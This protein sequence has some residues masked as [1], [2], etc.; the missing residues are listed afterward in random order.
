M[1][2]IACDHGGLELKAAVIKMLKARGEAVTDLGT[3][4][5]KSV[6]YPDYGF[7][8]AEK[9]AAESGSAG[10]VICKTGVGMS[11][12][13][14]KVKGVRCALCFTPEMGRLCREHNNANVLALGA[15]NTDIPA[16]LDIVE[17]FLTTEFAGGRHANRVGKIVNYEEQH[18]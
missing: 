2:Y 16:A 9:V 10:I 17:A 4:S 13:A 14:N 18:G 7:A 15:G 5:D 1:V 6:D 8:V 11:I 3:D 12:A